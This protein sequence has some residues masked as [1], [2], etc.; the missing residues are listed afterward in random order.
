MRFAMLFENAIA[1]CIVANGHKLFFYTHYSEE[2]HRNDMEI[3]FIISNNSK[4]KPKIYSI[5]VKAGKKYTTTSL[6]A[7]SKKYSKR[8]GRAYI[9]HPKN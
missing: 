9:I 4:T 8:I 2:K 3:D 1:Q 5:E 7:F 6:I